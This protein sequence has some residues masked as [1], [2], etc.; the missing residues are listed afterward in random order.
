MA[1]APLLQNA[2]E[3]QIF[4]GDTTLVPAEFKTECCQVSVTTL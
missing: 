2:R 3:F 4:T 1:G